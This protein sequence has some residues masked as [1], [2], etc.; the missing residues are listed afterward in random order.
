MKGATFRQFQ[1]FSLAAKHLSFARCAEELHLTAPAVSQQ[2]K[3]LETAVGLPLFDRSGR[4]VSL[5]TVGEYLLVYVR[6]VLSTM[7]EADD[8][9]SRFSRV[10]SG[11]LNVGMVT[12]AI[13]FVP[14]LLSQFQQQYPGIDI[15]VSL[16][17]NREH[18]H[19]LLEQRDI[20]LAIMGRTPVA[21]DTRTESLCA[22]PFV[23]VCAADH[24]VSPGHPSLESLQPY[25][26]LAREPGSGTRHVMQEFFDKQNFT[27]RIAL[28]LSSN[29]AI[30]Q[31]VIADLGVAFLSLHTIRLE[32][33]SRKLRII[34]IPGTPILRAWNVVSMPTHTL[35]PA[36]E[37]FRYFMLENAPQYLA[38]K[39][40]ELLA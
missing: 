7:K 27:P 31:A 39:D 3:E 38:E 13:F 40:A 5:T 28:E 23:F 36:A 1:V 4:Q 20:D 33:E 19:E 17:Q 29:E 11:V 12:T 15:R 22:H 34:H 21:L 8:F 18:M 10:E 37:S 25:S 2:I 30:K 9:I 16:A 14:E 24:P 26:F 35:S 32:L 6:R